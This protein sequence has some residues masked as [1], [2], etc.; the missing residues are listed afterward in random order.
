MT[1]R[2]RIRPL[3]LTAAIAVLAALFATRVFRNAVVR[4]AR[5][6]TPPA[7]RRI[8]PAGISGERA[9]AE[10]RDFV[11]LGP[12]VS[13]TPGA[14]R[15][16]RYLETR[17]RDLGVE[18]LLDEFRDETPAG[19]VL[20]RN[21]LGI[22]PGTSGRTLIVGSHYDTKAGISDRFAGANDS[23]SSTG[24]LLE[25]ARS[26]A[27]RGTRGPAVILAF[28]DGEECLR[29]YGAQDGLHG[30][31]RLA[32]TLVQN[33]RADRVTAVLVLDMVG[34]RDLTVTI[35]RNSTP[36]LISLAFESA[37]AEGARAKF[38]LADGPILDDHVPFR[39][40]GMPAVDL[41]DFQYGPVPGDNSTWHTDADTMDKLSA[42]S[43]EIVG[44]VVIRM[45]NA[46][47]SP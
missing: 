10:V 35:P 12:R 28:F 2:R 11:A 21:V 15:A 23:G 32:K 33:R 27:Q 14:E 30:S 39:A 40:A 46:L 16:A 29:A 25:L 19:P 9:L 44:R 31:R 18:P 4:R 8:D 7:P 37:R 24:L 5:R 41:I 34:D 36:A 3:L 45:L 22:V 47:S 43:L 26:L 13:G 38:S 42:R 17:L 20:F 1:G 6:E